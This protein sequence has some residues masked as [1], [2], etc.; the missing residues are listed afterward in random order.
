MTALDRAFAVNG[1]HVCSSMY[2]QIT[3]SINEIYD[4][5]CHASV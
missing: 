3:I 2:M 1:K 4:Q 5:L